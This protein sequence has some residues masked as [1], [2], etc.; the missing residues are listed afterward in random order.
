MRRT[1]NLSH[2]TNPASTRTENPAAIFGFVLRAQPTSMCAQLW[3]LGSIRGNVPMRGISTT[4]RG[5]TDLGR[6]P[7]ILRWRERAAGR[8]GPAAALKIL[9]PR[10]RSCGSARRAGD[11]AAAPVRLRKRQPMGGGRSDRRAGEG[12]AAPVR[13]RRRLPGREAA[14]EK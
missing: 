3:C 2:T 12:K 14:A 8:R 11:G 1:R 9:G 6:R 5:G 10:P 7:K 13:L 4:T